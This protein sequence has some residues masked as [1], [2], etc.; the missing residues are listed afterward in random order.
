VSDLFSPIR[1]G[2]F[3]APNRFVRSATHEWMA[4]GDGAVSDRLCKVYGDLA[5]GGVGLIDMAYSF[6]QPDGQTSPNQIAIHDDRFIEGQRRLVDIVHA[7]PSKIVMQIVHGGRRAT[8]A[9]TGTEPVAP[10]TVPFRNGDPAPREIS[11]AQIRAV[12]GAFGD[13]AR[14]AR[15]AGHDGVQL[16]CAHG[17]LLSS[18]ISPHYNRRTD[19]WGGSVPNRARILLEIMDSC[20]EKAGSDFPVLIKINSSDGFPGGTSHEDL[21]ETCRMLDAHG[22][23]AIEVSGGGPEAEPEQG[24][25]RTRVSK[26][27]E[28]AYFAEPAAKVKQ[29]VGCPVIAVGGLRSFSVMQSLLEDGVADMVSLSRPFIR[30]PDLVDL[31]A[32]GSAEKSDCISCNKCYNNKGIRC[33]HLDLQ[34]EQ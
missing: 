33:W 26:P 15:E 24:A 22:I 16:H 18:F 25:S 10:S 19:G 3:Q 31:F 7:T 11:E 5:T 9:L 23:A 27:Q 2:G 17:F 32:Q 12:I 28:E 6:V 29:A 34:R 30:Q 13:A 21:V 20:R 1:I 14:R 4:T 8:P